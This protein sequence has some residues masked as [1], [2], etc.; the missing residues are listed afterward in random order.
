MNPLTERLD[1]HGMR[2]VSVVGVI[3]MSLGFGLASLSTEVSSAPCLFR[4]L[5]ILM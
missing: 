5:G 3:C 4:T 2:W 1:N